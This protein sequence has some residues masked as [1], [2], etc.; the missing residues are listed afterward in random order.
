MLDSMAKLYQDTISLFVLVNTSKI[1]MWQLVHVYDTTQW[2]QSQELNKWH[3]DLTL[4]SFN[5]Q[6]Y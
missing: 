4:R 5:S 1:P 2:E 6:L 3:S